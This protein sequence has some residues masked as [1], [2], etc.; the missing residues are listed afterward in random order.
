[1][2]KEMQQE[3][4]RPFIDMLIAKHALDARNIYENRTAGDFTFT[5]LFADFVNDLRNN[6]MLKE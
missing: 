6:G 2:A 1:M 5:G 4:E 3:S